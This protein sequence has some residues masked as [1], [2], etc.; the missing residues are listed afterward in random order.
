MGQ[1]EI[2]VI[3]SSIRNIIARDTNGGFQKAFF[4]KIFSHVIEKETVTA[5]EFHRLL[6]ILLESGHYRGTVG[7]RRLGIVSGIS[8]GLGRRTGQ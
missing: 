5:R 7:V 4:D 1:F 3:Q 2:T 6:A 8:P